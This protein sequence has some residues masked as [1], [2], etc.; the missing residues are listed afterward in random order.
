M[1][2]TPPCWDLDELLNREITIEIVGGREISGV[3]K[4]FDQLGNL[5]IEN[6]LEV[7][8]FGQKPEEYTPRSLETAVIRSPHIVNIQI[9][10]NR[11]E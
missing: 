5:V 2:R 10:S 6:S 7:T 4:G 8:P 1:D 11:K 9:N 3:L